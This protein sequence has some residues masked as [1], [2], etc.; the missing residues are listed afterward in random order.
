MTRR[1]KLDIPPHLSR[2]E[3]EVVI[4]VL[5]DVLDLLC[6]HLHELDRH[7]SPDDHRWKNPAW[8]DEL[9]EHDEGD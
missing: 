7:A 9:V 4:D 3:T 1:Y 8:V 6:R 5:E 2:E